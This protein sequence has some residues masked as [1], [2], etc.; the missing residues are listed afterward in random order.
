LSSLIAFF[1]QH[2]DEE[3]ERVRPALRD[4]S[5]TEELINVAKTAMSVTS[6]QAKARNEASSV[7]LVLFFTNSSLLALQFAVF[8]EGS[9]STQK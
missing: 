8:D 6:E 9:S 3:E 5:T 2:L 1:L 4:L 7:Y